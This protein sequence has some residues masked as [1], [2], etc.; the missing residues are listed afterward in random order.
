MLKCFSINKSAK[1]RNA[2]IVI[3]I[4]SIDAKTQDD[5]IAVV[6]SVLLRLLL[7]HKL[8]DKIKLK[9]IKH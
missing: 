8:F 4:T 5:E 9:I 2:G 7:A 3:K 1:Y 6:I